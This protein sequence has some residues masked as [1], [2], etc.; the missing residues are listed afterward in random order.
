[1]IKLS[2]NVDNERAQK[3]YE[4][5]DC[6]RVSELKNEFVYEKNL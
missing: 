1:M 5:M 3:F 2:T 4:K 6:S